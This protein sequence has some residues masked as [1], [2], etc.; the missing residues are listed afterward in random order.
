M[1]HLNELYQEIIIDHSRSPRN[2]GNLACCTHQAEGFNPLCGDR[3]TLYLQINDNKITAVKFEG[4]G[5]AI[6]TATAS[7]MS[8]ALVGKTPQEAEA[9]FNSFRSLV[10]E[11][12]LQDLPD[13]GKL[14]VLAG[15]KEFPMRVKCATLAWHTLL[16]ALKQQTN[17]VTTE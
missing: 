15:V 3:I 1:S 9:L 17:Q 6:S 7:L 10:T 13:I 8:E 16:A 12:N 5:C 2:K 11:N 4:E 14:N